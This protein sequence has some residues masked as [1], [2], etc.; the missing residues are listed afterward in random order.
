MGRLPTSERLWSLSL[1]T[2]AVRF[3]DWGASQAVAERIFANHIKAFQQ[4][5]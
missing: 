5:P 1:G 4:T 2:G 3:F